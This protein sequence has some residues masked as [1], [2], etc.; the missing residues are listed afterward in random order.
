M[1]LILTGATGLV[2][3]AVLD[4]MLRSPDVAR[5]SIL[6]RRPVAMAD[7]YTDPKVHVIQHR[8]FGNYNTEVLEQLEGANGVVWALGI[9]Q[10][11]VG[12]E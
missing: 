2:G 4:A 7:S 6:S 9:A 1:H 3:S 5:I 8:D 12:K 11:K 10:S